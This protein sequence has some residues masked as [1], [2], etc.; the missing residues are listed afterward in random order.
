[1]WGYIN[2]SKGR[3]V[4]HQDFTIVVYLSLWTKFLLLMAILHIRSMSALTRL[5]EHHYLGVTSKS[6]PDTANSSLR[7]DIPSSL[8]RKY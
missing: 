6:S 8:H 7:D 4:M 5:Q 3:I 2:N 1:V